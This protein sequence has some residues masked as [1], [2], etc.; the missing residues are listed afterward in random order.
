[1]F[2]YVFYD[3]PQSRLGT[4]VTFDST[5]W[6]LRARGSRETHSYSMTCQRTGSNEKTL[7]IYVSGRLRECSSAT[8]YGLYNI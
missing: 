5:A 7:E 2:P 3:G 8:P 6:L 1:M 4:L